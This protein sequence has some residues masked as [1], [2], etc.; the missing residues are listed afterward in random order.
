MRRFFGLTLLAILAIPPPAPA[1]SIDYTFADMHWPHS[2]IGH[3]E[4]DSAALARG[5]ITTA[6][7]TGFGFQPFGAQDL[8]P[9]TVAIDAAGVPTGEA[10]LAASADFY[11]SI[12]RLTVD[13]GPDAFN[14]LV[15][16]SYQATTGNYP[17]RYGYGCWAA[18]IDVAPAA[19]VPEPAGLVAMGL[20]IA[21][22][23]ILGIVIIIREERS[24]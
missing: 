20:G 10:W 9:F 6:D 17:G 21:C 14:P 23:V 19:A 11:G 22:G 8:Q 24:P 15:G 16:G 7:V 2:G 4:V 13:F 12:Y 5:Y 18:T 1:G 3:M